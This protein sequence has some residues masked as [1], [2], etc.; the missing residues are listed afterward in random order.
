[1]TKKTIISIVVFIV[2][3]L[4]IVAGTILI[5]RNQDIREKAAPLTSLSFSPTSKNVSKG[6]SFSTFSHI[7]SG[8][9]KVTGIDIEIIYDPQ[10]IQIIQ[11]QPTGQLSNFSSVVKNEIDNNTGKAK[12]IAF[13]VDKSL[14]IT[15][16]FNI[17]N[18]TA[19]VL[20]TA[21]VGTYQISYG[22]ETKIAAVGESQ[23][24]L[25]NKSATTIN[26]NLSAVTATP[27]IIATP[28][29]TPTRTPTA[30]PRS[31]AT[32]TPTRTPTATP[33]YPAWDVDRN[34]LINIVDIGIVVDDYDRTNPI[35][36]RS[37]VDKSG[38]VDI[39]DIG[40]IV[41]HYQL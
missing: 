2:L 10:I 17:L 25:L 36:P 30:T 5:S 13:T 9:N 3:A 26:V 34:G 20:N 29:P 7:N 23:N 15:G 27:T 21:P 31:T 38:R 12:Y 41:D 37:D 32:P 40:I 16:N 35:N 18:I 1:M 14:G 24:V 8:T 6:Q 22:S 11:I 19:K 4:G 39:V 28:K 33:T